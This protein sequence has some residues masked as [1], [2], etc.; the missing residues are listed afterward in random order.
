MAA[1]G[2][3]AKIRKAVDTA[4]KELGRLLATLQKTILL[5]K[6]GK[7][8]PKK[9]KAVVAKVLAAM[10]K[11]KGVLKLRNDKCFDE[12]PEDLRD[13]VI[14]M[15]ALMTALMAMQDKLT[16]AVKLMKREPESGY[17]VL[18]K[19]G[20]EAAM[21][22]GQAPKHITVMIKEIRKGVGEDSPL[23]EQLSM[24]P[25]IMTLSMLS[26]AIVQG[27]RDRP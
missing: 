10:K 20:K 12:L 7:F 16:R 3:E 17:K 26:D 23:R 9:A 15:D 18:L 27:L 5:V 21:E 13:R 8:S 6:Q 14:W 2:D 4:E 19:A 22:I 25:M 24:M 1:A 11:H